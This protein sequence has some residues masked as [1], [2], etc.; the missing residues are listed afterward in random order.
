VAHN[1]REFFELSA[2]C[3]FGPDCLHRNE[4]KCAVKAA[5]EAEE[6]SELR[7]MNYLTILGEI[8]EQKYWERHKG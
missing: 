4:P 8:E 5:L 2:N 1:F 3:R 7:Y 6:V